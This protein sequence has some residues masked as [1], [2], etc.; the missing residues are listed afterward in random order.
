MVLV[1][2]SPANA[3]R[4][5][6]EIALLAK[7]FTVFAFD[8]PGFGLSEALPLE[9]MEVGDLADALAETLRTLG[10]PRCAVYG[11]HTGAAI[12]LELGVRHPDR[13]T[14][15]V[16]DG[17]PA[18]T[19]DETRHLFDNYFKTIS[20]D[21]LGGHY[22]ATWT[23]FRDQSIWFP[24]TRREPVQLNEYDL[25][26]P[27]V[28]DL[29]VSMYFEGAETYAP[30]YR[31]ACFY[32]ARALAAISAL[33]LPAVFMAVPTDMLR[34]H[35]ARF[36]MLKPEQEIVDIDSIEQKLDV[37]AERL[38]KYGAEGTAPPD[39]DAI[40]STTAVVRQF[41]DGSAGPLHL[42]T[43]GSRDGLAVLL[44]HDAPGSGE[45]LVPVMRALSTSCF[46]VAP[47][48][49]GHG[50]SSA[51]AAQ[52]AITDFASEMASLLSRLGIDS[53]VVVG[54]GF[55]SSVAIELARREA[56]R[57]AKLGLCGLLL[58]D[59][60]ERA[61]LREHYTPPVNISA[62]GSHWYRTWLMLRDSQIYWPWFDTTVGALRRVDQDFS[63]QRLH[64]WTM[65]VMR[66]RSAYHHL[67]QA[68][69]AHDAAVALGALSVP[70]VRV[71]DPSRPLSVYDARLR[72]LRGEAPEHAMSAFIAS[73]AAAGHG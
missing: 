67:V 13:V 39:L 61:R 1:H 51:Y 31:A 32:G 68:A 41:V 34:P 45:Q 52:P 11:T 28:T 12:A 9:T 42:R 30:A 73:L 8:T 23:R 20:V 64:R 35:L 37:T 27:E 48:L 17:V 44:V 66:N 19:K 36:P 72:S 63:G 6:P 10:M 2:S 5:A 24:W 71:T 21:D 18:F 16:L 29:W 56:P 58:P 55:G 50:E 26:A 15:L 4:L 65:D 43:A 49:P 38:A 33:T 46:V 57:V 62:D 54:I 60:A 14:G 53:A 7:K 59:A 47:D 3:R 40:C 70:L 69:L 22:A 25:E